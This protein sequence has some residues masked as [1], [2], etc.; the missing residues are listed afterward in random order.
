[1][2]A[3]TQLAALHHNA[4]TG[5]DQ[6]TTSTG[7]LRFKVV[8]PKRTKDWVA[9]PIREKAKKDHLGAL[10]DAIVARKSLDYDDRSEG[11]DTSH[12]ALNI[13][14]KPRPEKRAVIAQHISRFSRS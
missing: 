7:E 14:T 6:A 5:R 4:N 3:R 12:I 10:L 13:A 9:K 8:F 2:I 1:M 11:L